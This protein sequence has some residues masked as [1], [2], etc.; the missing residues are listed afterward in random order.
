MYFWENIC[1]TGA[2]KRS[3]VQQTQQTH[4]VVRGI[5]QNYRPYL[6]TLSLRRRIVANDDY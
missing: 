4:F 6:T 3:Q 2:V 5:F 1:I